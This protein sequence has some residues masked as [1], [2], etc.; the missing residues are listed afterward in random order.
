MDVNRRTVLVGSAAIALSTSMPAAAMTVMG[1]DVRTLAR[2]FDAC[3]DHHAVWL[4]AW[5]TRW[6]GPSWGKAEDDRY[7]HALMDIYGSGNRLFAA[8]AMRAS[9][10]DLKYEMLWTFGEKT[11]LHSRRDLIRDNFAS[12][13]DHVTNDLAE[14]DVDLDYW[15]LGDVTG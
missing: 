15:W 5:K 10:A 2:Q 6:P 7:F 14:F 4:Q 9:D 12:W 3:L 13:I 1:E 11:D 8:P